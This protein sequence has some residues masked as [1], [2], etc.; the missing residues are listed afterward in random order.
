MISLQQSAIQMQLRLTRLYMYIYMHPLLFFFFK[1]KPEVFEI[2]KK[3]ST[4]E[5]IRAY[6]NR[7]GAR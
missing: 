6:S 7:S 1:H 3:G 2:K 4:L 5:Y